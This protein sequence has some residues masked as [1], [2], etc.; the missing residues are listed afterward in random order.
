MPILVIEGPLPHGVSCTR[1]SKSLDE[2]AIARKATFLMKQF[3]GL[4]GGEYMM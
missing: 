3:E 4:K 2:A 1:W